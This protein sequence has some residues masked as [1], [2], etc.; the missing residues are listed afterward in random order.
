LWRKSLTIPTSSS[1]CETI[2]KLQNS[3]CDDANL[4]DL[5]KTFVLILAGA[6]M[7]LHAVLPLLIQ[8]PTRRSSSLWNADY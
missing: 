1:P 5:K 4:L 8:P 2:P 7:R 3:G 6:S